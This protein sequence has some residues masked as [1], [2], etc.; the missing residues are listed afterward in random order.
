MNQYLPLV[1]NIDPHH[2]PS[3]STITLAALELFAT[4][5]LPQITFPE[6]KRPL[7]VG[8]G[9]ALVTAQI[10]FA[11]SDAIFANENNYQQAVTKQPDGA[12]IFSASG[13]K[14]ASVIAKHY[15]SLN[16]PTTLVTCNPD[17]SAGQIL[18]SQHTIV[19]PK[20]PEPYTYNTSTYLGWI[21]AKTHENPLQIL[22]FIT[23]QLQPTL[24]DTL[25]NYHGY[26]L[27]T[28]DFFSPGN[29][30]FD[31]K[32]TEL[33]G[34]RVARDIRTFEELKH[35]VTVVPYDQELLIS[36]GSPYNDYSGNQLTLPLPK[37]PGPATIMA[38]GYY[39]IGRIQ[40]LKPQWFQKSIGDYISHVS[41]TPFGQGLSVIVN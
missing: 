19:T 8:S 24:P 5:G 23:T 37:D 39:T 33:F 11:D 31:I 21:L 12:I 25:G 40:E 17:S 26:L 6:Y 38:I 1:Q 34:R 27:I 4:K 20:N 36:F 16:L 22:D 3:L 29:R 9:N 14:H 28:P 10:L 30:L 7:V 35:A 2:L 13:E 15:H 18:G 32:F 41:S